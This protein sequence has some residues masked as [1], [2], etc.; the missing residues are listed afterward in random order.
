MINCCVV[1]KCVCGGGCYAALAQSNSSVKKIQ[2]LIV[3]IVTF[4]GG[5]TETIFQAMRIHSVTCKEDFFLLLLRNPE[6]FFFFIQWLS[7]VLNFPSK[8]LTPDE[9]SIIAFLSAVRPLLACCFL[10]LWHSRDSMKW[11]HTI[12][13][14][15]IMTR[16]L[17]WLR[18]QPSL[19]NLIT[20]AER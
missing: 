10:S 11:S 3:L 4:I 6:V 20:I 14:H 18:F 15:R 9:K 17:W 19:N 13:V 7:S 5:L 8:H 12:E 16:Q 2:T 1:K